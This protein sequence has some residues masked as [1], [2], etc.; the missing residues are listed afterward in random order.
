MAL[1]VHIEELVLHGFDPRDRHAFGD[2][3]RAELGQLLADGR[4]PA[5]IMAGNAE[6]SVEIDGIR[7]PSAPRAIA[8]AIHREIVR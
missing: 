4:R 6:T 8:G 7:S 5:G 2:A 3:I 1:I